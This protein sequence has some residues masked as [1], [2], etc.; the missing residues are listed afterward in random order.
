MVNRAYNK[1]IRRTILASPGRYIA[2]LA[3]VALGVGFFAGVKN[4]KASMIETCNKYVTEYN[5]YDYRLVSTWGFTEEDEKALNE[6]KEVADAEGSVTQDFF[7]F[8]SSGNSIILRAHSFTEKLNGVKLTA[9]RMAESPDEC[10]ADEHF[11]TSED[12]GTKINVAN[13]ND[14]DTKGRFRFKEYTITGI[15]NSPMYIMKTERGTGSLGDGRITAYVYIPKKG[16]DYEYYT[17]M[18]LTCSKQG[19]VYSDE[20]DNNIKAAKMPVTEAAETRG[21]LRYNEVMDEGRKEI[22][23]ARG[24]LDEGRTE[25]EEGRRKLD[26]GRAELNENRSKLKNSKSIAYA[27]LKSNREKL[28][29]G[30]REIKTQSATLSKEK[31]K[32]NEQ[33]KQVDDGILQ[34]E[35]ALETMISSGHED[36]EAKAALEMQ[37]NQL[38][39]TQAKIGNGL[40]KISAGEKKLE[41]E[42][43]KIKSGY[44]KYYSGKAEADSNFA[45]AERKLAEAE[46]ELERSEQKLVKA[47]QELTEAEEELV[48]AEKELAETEKPE[49]YIQTRSDNTGYESFDSNSDI[50]DSIAK[51]FPI[52]FFLI[53]ALVCSTTMSRMIEEERT[54]IGT[55][56][57]LGYTRMRI[58]WKYIAYSGSAAIT[59]CIIG[60]LAGSRYFPYAIWIAYGMMFGFGPLEFYFSWPLAIV[61]LVVALICSAGTTYIACRGQLK[62]MPAEI[63]RPRAP[64][65]GRR[66]ILERI[67]PLWSKLSFLH[68]VTARNIFRY[69]KRMIMMIMGIGGCTALVIAGFGINDSVAGLA[70]HQYDQIETYDMTVAFSTE[71]NKRELREF[72]MAY[73][74][75]IESKAMLHQM[76]VNAKSSAGVKSCNLMISG[77]SNITKAVHF[78]DDDRSFAYPKKGE[79]LI[80]NKLAEMLKLEE[81]DNVT[82]EYDETKNVKLQITGIY[83]NYVSN[84][85]Y[86]NDETYEQMMN[87]S[88]EPE[89]C[90]ITLKDASDVYHVSEKINQFGQTAGISVIDSVKSRVDDMMVSLNYIIILVIG[91][92]G[93]LAFIVLFNLGNINITER[94]REIA[95]IEVLGF[96]PRETGAYV[97]RENF[98]LVLIGIA[99]GMPA[100]YALH[101]FIMSQIIVDA[102]TFNDVIEPQSFLYSALT[103]ILF[104]LIVDVI[105]R[106]K[107]RRIN[108]AEALKSIE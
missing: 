81:G 85:I 57:A 56:R 9:G 33:K 31:T 46:K 26:E 3:I 92:A 4:T 60:F 5:L 97:F 75:D 74:D 42:E 34:A 64:K 88:Y 23:S 19:Y 86:I 94:Q 77:D 52:F 53:A 38:K 55:M 30:S 73:G 106:R 67:T 41:K 100:G 39:I 61:S 43:R 82:V 44:Q 69:K 76:A 32:L 80:N 22:E 51:V 101:K 48:K 54:Q 17:E 1:N 35:T 37:I 71:L 62:D 2:I 59:G 24:E 49:L 98:I 21:E 27:E 7:S 16:F 72:D 45:S 10:V 99:F 102:V 11:F 47:E 96:Y 65:A 103:V 29:R 79:A 12:I 104:A 70:D 36:E 63:L 14:K 83:R 95:T 90:F 66:I 107:L 84:Y 91:C 93:A 18:Y 13:K 78:K 87:K 20:Y 28:E 6:V 15:V 108:M 50:V 8:D 40:E 105:M 25:L 58:I 68:K 89:I